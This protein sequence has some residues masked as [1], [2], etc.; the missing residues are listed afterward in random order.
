MFGILAVGVCRTHQRGFPDQIIQTEG[1]T[2]DEIEALRRTTKSK[3]YIDGNFKCTAASYYDTKPV[4]MLSTFHMNVEEIFKLRLVWNA[5]ARAKEQ[6][7]IWRLNIIDFYNQYMD[8]VD[9][10]DQLRW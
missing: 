10:Q 1:S 9:M 8:G 7:K 5:A 3:V 6:I 4:H 2:K